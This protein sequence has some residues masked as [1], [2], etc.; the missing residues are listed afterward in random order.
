MVVRL[1][2]AGLAAALGAGVLSAAAGG[3]AEGAVTLSAAANAVRATTAWDVFAHQDG[4]VDLYLDAP[5][6][7]SYLAKEIAATTDIAKGMAQESK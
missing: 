5:S 4:Q 7:Q 1:V 2:T 6:F 3:R